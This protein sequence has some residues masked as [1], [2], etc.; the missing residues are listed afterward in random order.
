MTIHRFLDTGL[1]TSGLETKTRVSRHAV[2]CLHKCLGK[3]W[4]TLLYYHKECLLLSRKHRFV[5]QAAGLLTYSF[6]LSAFPKNEVFSGI[7]LSVKSLQQRELLGILTRF[8]VGPRGTAY[9]RQRY[10]I[11]CCATRK[12]KKTISE[13]FRRA[14]PICQILFL[15][16]S[17]FQ[18]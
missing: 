16:Q 3:R 18:M 2:S 10:T 13:S 14:S 12:I 8:P 5:R 17:A 11:F 1:E 6:R 9:R 4:Y 7:V 15:L